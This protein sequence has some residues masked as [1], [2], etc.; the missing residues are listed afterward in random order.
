MKSI[1]IHCTSLIGIATLFSSCTNYLKSDGKVYKR[2][3]NAAM[4]FGKTE[5][6]S[7][8]YNTFK[9]LNGIFAYD[10]NHVYRGLTILQGADVASFCIVDEGKGYYKDRSRV[11]FFGYGGTDNVIE[12]ADPSSFG[13]ASLLPW[14]FDSKNVF[15]IKNKLI[16]KPQPDFK[17]INGH[18]AKDGSHIYYHNAAVDSADRESFKVLDDDYAKDKFHV[19]FENKIIQNCPPEDF[20]TMR[21][22]GAHDKTYYYYF[23]ERKELLSEYEA[24]DKLF[25]QQLK[26]PQR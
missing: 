22:F 6:P 9:R 1:F 18:W 14:S 23:G 2:Y 11:Y 13:I 19:F 12:E 25:R 21:N 7:A 5:I 8:D 15:W 3:A 16:P 20:V 17:P 24:K 26:H 10:K 4:G